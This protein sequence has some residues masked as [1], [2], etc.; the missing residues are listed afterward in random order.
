M[1]WK[2]APG[3]FST[4][5]IGLISNS[6]RTRVLLVCRQR[7]P[8]QP[9]LQLWP[10]QTHCVALS[11]VFRVRRDYV[12]MISVCPKARTMKIYTHVDTN[13]SRVLS[14]RAMLAAELGYFYLE[15]N[16]HLLFY[17]NELWFEM[18]GR[19]AFQT[20][21]VTSEAY[22]SLNENQSRKEANPR[23]PALGLENKG[24]PFLWGP[25]AYL[26]PANEEKMK[27]WQGGNWEFSPQVP[28]KYPWARLIFCLA[29]CC[30]CLFCPVSVTV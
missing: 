8:T 28:A 1:P 9:E 3:E 19:Q 6:S 7:E 27:A 20:T 14:L 18:K 12:C 22:L 21:L 15:K 2:E 16:L 13:E 10:E 11:S 30:K 26:R 17:F 23:Q 25:E 29:A 24:Q 4:A 5:R